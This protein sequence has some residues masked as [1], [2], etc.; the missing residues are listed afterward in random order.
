MLRYCLLLTATIAPS[1]VP[2]LKRDKKFER[3]DDYIKSLKFWLSFHV[4]IVFVENSNYNSKIINELLEN[5]DEC[6]Y[7]KFT[8]TTS[9]LGK[10]HGEAEII[11]YAFNNSRILDKC[12][13]IVKVTGRLSIK[14]F[15]ELIH[16]STYDKKFFVMSG[17]NSNL[18][19]SDSKLIIAKKDFYTSYLIPESSRLD[20]EKSIYFE[21]IF[22]QAIHRCIADGHEW[23]L[24]DKTP[25]FAGFSGTGN[26]EYKYSLFYILK[27]NIM[28][29]VMK[30]LLS[31]QP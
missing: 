10:G 17:F 29:K 16:Y 18:T 31:I 8:S 27:H 21:H 26:V 12:D 30:Y 28:L 6:E 9:Y 24:M 22:A 7:L 3:E 2:S 14:N 13:T 5:N 19:F 23:N 25:L 20:E 11:K 1:N 15:S 4:P